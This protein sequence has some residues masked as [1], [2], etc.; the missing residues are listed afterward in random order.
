MSDKESGGRADRTQPDG[1]YDY[2]GRTDRQDSGNRVGDGQRRGPGQSQ[3]D[4]EQ[5]FRDE[6]WDRNSQSP[7]RNYRIEN[8]KQVI[9]IYDSDVTIGC[10]DQSTF[11]RRPCDADRTCDPDYAMRR[12]DHRR[13]QW[14]RLREE[15]DCID[16]R[17]SGHYRD[18]VD[19]QYRIDQRRDSSYNRTHVYGGPNGYEY[20]ET[21]AR[22]NRQRPVYNSGC[23][24][25]GSVGRTSDVG[26][27]DSY[28]GSEEARRWIG[29]IGGIVIADQYARHG[30]GNYYGNDHGNNYDRFNQGQRH[31]NRYD[32]PDYRDYQ[33]QRWYESHQR[34]D[35]DYER[36]Y[37]ERQPDNYNRTRT[38]GG[39]GGFEMDEQSASSNR[40]RNGDDY[41]ANDSY[42]DSAEARKWIGTLGS[43]FI[44]GEYASRS[45][46][47]NNN[48]NYD[49]YQ[50]YYNRR[51]G[52]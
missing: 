34:R 44:A 19:E 29:T 5:A 6:A 27:D 31:Y 8:D 13:D 12:D 14:R 10:S 22:T 1:N 21:S 47:H 45:G 51:H 24:G 4:C 23:F 37:Y 32:D 49:Q 43:L 46:R 36:P 28:R 17:R 25:D 3:S 41:G 48:N 50:N 9:N 33:R 35:Y 20:D 16:S 26:V 40:G 30:R 15:Q 2:Y 38:Y 7:R 52:R 42:R 39:P 11:R 18:R